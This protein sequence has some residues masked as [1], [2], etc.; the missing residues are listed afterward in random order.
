MLAM[1]CGGLD[2][3]AVMAGFPYR[4]VRPKV[5][6]VRLTGKLN[7]P[8]VTA[9]DVGLEMLRRLTVRGGVGWIMEYSGPGLKDLIRN[10]TGNY[11]QPGGRARGYDID[12]SQ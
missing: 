1:G 5:R 12:L 9:M 7:R 8:W 10:R 3:A 4:L 6:Q 11:L 2:I